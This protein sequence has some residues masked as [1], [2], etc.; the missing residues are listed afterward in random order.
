MPFVKKKSKGEKQGDMA[1]GSKNARGGGDK[2]AKAVV[3]D[4]ISQAVNSTANLLHLM[5][6]SSSAQVHSS[7]P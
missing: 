6:Q 3:A 4:Q 7:N 5:R 1:T 2:T